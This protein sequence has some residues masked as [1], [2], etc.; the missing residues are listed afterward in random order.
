MSKAK[1]YDPSNSDL[2][3]FSLKKGHFLYVFLAPLFLSVILALGKQDFSAFLYNLIAFALFLLPGLI[4][5]IKFG[6]M[7]A[8]HTWLTKLTAVVM[9]LGLILLLFTK[10]DLLFHVSI[11]FLFLEAIEHLGITLS[12]KQPQSNVKSLWHVIKKN[13]L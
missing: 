8:Y 13:A 9:S 12:L 1:R 10:N 6:E 7:V 2:Q 3:K 11:Y 4:A 5:R